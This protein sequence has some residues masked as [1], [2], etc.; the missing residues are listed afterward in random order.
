MRNEFVAFCAALFCIIN[1]SAQDLNN[2]YIGVHVYSGFNNVLNDEYKESSDFH[3]DKGFLIGLSYYRAVNDYIMWE[4]GFNFSRNFYSVTVELDNE[5][6]SKVQ[7]LEIIGLPLLFLAKS[8]NGFFVSAGMQLDIE[9]NHWTK[10]IISNQSGLGA[11][12]S[13]GKIFHVSE[14]YY[15]LMAPICKIHS[16]IPFNNGSKYKSVEYG[17]KITFNYGF[18]Q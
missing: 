14:N 12:L 8:S 18:L 16:I 3:S 15:I 6:W 10:H 2:N 9:V 5:R 17:I 7:P 1:V 4:S 13:V 11:N